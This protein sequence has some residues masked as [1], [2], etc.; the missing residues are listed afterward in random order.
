LIVFLMAAF[1]AIMLYKEMPDVAFEAQRQKEQ[2]LIDRGDEYEHAIKLFYRRNQR[3][4]TALDQLDKFNNIRYIRHRFKDPLTG[5]DEWRLIHISGPGFS[6]TDSKVTPP[7][8]DTSQNGASAFGSQS[9]ASTFGSSNSGTPSSPGDSSS[10]SDQP[11]QTEPAALAHRRPP[12]APANSFAAGAQGQGQV[13]PGAD[14]NQ[15][16]P[17]NPIGGGAF[18]PNGMM[19][20]GMIGPNGMQNGRNPAGGRTFSENGTAATQPQS[21]Q[22][23]SG[24]PQNA[25][26]PGLAAVNNAL[27]Q[28]GQTASIGTSTMGT[29]FAAGS[30]AGVASKGKGKSIKVID[31]QTDYAKWEFVYNPQKEMEKKMSAAMPSPATNG[32]GQ[33]SSPFFSQPNSAAPTPSTGANTPSQ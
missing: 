24:Q 4:P 10:A 6:L 29:M 19:P 33:T 8:T 27:R 12:E 15:Q 1:V 25:Q 17:G 13:T 23:Q 22:P 14:A 3:F 11:N 20:N 5:K 26:D 28:P 9:T 30:I 32:P 16:Q 7:K 2:T 18:P 21:G 31:K